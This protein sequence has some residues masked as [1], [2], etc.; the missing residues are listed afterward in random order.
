MRWW[1]LGTK[2]EDADDSE[3]DTSA[4]GETRAC[5]TSCSCPPSPSSYTH[6]HTFADPTEATMKIFSL[7]VILAPPRAQC[8]VLST[9]SDLST[10]SFYQ[11][12]SVGEFLSFFSK[13]I[14][15]RTPQG[16]RQSVQE[17]NYTAHV[18]NRGGAE[19][20]AGKTAR[21]RATRTPPHTW[22]WNEQ[23]SSSRT[24]STPSAP[25][26]PCSRRCWMTSQ[27]RYPSR[28]SRTPP[29]SASRRS[30][31]TF[32]SIRTQGRRMRS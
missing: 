8:T 14:V 20:L 10:F 24:R 15:D 28:R 31:T 1:W 11:R 26:S 21:H 19:Q 18:Y 9:A 6:P 2:V 5:H 3:R 32:R 23:R 7:S 29:R 17:N 22:H 16:Q 13:T 30:T 4:V 25:H 12:G 27:P